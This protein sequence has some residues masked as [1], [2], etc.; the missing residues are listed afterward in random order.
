[1]TIIATILQA[2]CWDTFSWKKIFVFSFGFHRSFYLTVKLAILVTWCLANGK[3]LMTWTN[4]WWPSWLTHMC[5]IRFLICYINACRGEKYWYSR[6]CCHLRF[7][8]IFEIFPINPLRPCDAYISHWTERQAIRD[9][10]DLLVQ[11]SCMCIYMYAWWWTSV[12]IKFK[13]YI[14]AQ[15]VCLEYYPKL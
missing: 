3:P 1:M 6:V 10:A 5:V 8:V 14:T 2:I 13:R 15:P 9:N 7:Y 12:N 11:F 4:W